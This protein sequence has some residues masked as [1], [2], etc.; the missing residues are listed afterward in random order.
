MARPSSVVPRIMVALEE[1]SEQ[2]YQLPATSDRKV[3]VIALCRELK[4]VNEADAQHFH[5]KDEI[6]NFVNA[7]AAEQGLLPI[8]HRA[9]QDEAT[10]ELQDRIRQLSAQAKEDAQSAVEAISSQQALLDELKAVKS[11]LAQKDLEIAALRE[12]L[13]VIEE[14]CFIVRF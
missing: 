14:D 6:K 10:V 12:R 7:L 8:G 2:G 1:F 13:R 3:N 9:F 11:V 4:G 5:K